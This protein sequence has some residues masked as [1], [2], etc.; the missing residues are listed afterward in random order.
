MTQN[1]FSTQQAIYAYL[2][3]EADFPIYD[4]NMPE[5]ELEPR[6]DAGYMVPYAV[7]RFNDAIKVPRMGAVGGARLDEMYSLVDI[8]CVGESPDEARELAYGVDGVN[9][10]LVGY[11]PV[12]AGELTKSGGG[13]VFVISDGS[14]T[15]PTRYVARCSFRFL[16]NMES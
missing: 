5:G 8:L 14:G 11:V 1:L 15:R 13:Q 16:V 6:S 2:D 4:T 3:A 7:V 12:D 10:I 9:D